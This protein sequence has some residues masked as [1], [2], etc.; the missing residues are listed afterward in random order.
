[1]NHLIC[2]GSGQLEERLVV[3]LYA[4]TNGTISQTQTQFGIDE[5]CAT[6]EYSTIETE[7]ELIQEGIGR[8]ESLKASD[9]INIDFDAD[10][11]PAGFFIDPPAA[12]PDKEA[13]A[14]SKVFGPMK[15]YDK[16]NNPAEEEMIERRSR[17]ERHLAETTGPGDFG[18]WNYGDGHSI[19]RPAVNRWD[20]SWRTWKGYHHVSGSVPWILALRKTGWDEYK[21]AI[22]VSRHLSDI[23]IC[24]YETEQSIERSKKKYAVNNC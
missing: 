5:I 7:E 17:L 3:H 18:K 6:Y 10:S 9:E 8:F 23:D 2:L 22:A 1:M 12:L 4:D 15:V 21:R 24:H 20:D 13:V 11:E 19:W 14:A 16:K